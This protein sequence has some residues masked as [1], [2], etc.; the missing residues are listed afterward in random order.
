[1]FI[2]GCV[3]VL[4]DSSPLISG[5]VFASMSWVWHHVFSL[6]NGWMLPSC[7]PEAGV[8]SNISEC[9][10]RCRRWHLLGAFQ[11]W[12]GKHY[13]HLWVV[14]VISTG[15][16]N[17]VSEQVTAE[18]WGRIYPLATPF[19]SSGLSLIHYLLSCRSFL[20]PAQKGSPLCDHHP[21]GVRTPPIWPAVS[22]IVCPWAPSLNIS[23]PR[24]PHLEGAI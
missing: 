21:Q 15:T 3:Q 18:L 6:W 20:I 11:N 4:L 19:S 12:S 17:L 16:W 10:L 1:M 14:G 8:M 22:A 13:S 5:L 2:T 9:R 7:A 24:P 23:G